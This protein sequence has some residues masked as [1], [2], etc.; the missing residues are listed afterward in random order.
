MIYEMFFM[1]VIT[2]ILMDFFKLSYEEKSLFY[3]PASYYANNKY[4]MNI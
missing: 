2:K 4:I 1:K 3:I